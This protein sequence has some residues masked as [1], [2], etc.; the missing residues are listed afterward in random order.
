M[1]FRWHPA[2]QGRAAL[3]L[4]EWAVLAS[5]V[6]VLGGC[7]SALFLVSLDWATRTREA[8]PWLVL[9]LPLGGFAVGLLYHAW[10]KR[11]EGGTNLLLDEIHA[12]SA[13]VPA[14]LAPLV[15]V[16]TVATHLFGGS[17]G[18]EGTAVQM[19][20]SLAATLGRLLRLDPGRVRLL[21]MA[22]ISAGFGS[23]FGT[24]LAGM[25]FGMEVL[26][27][28]RMR[29]YALVP[30]LVASLVGDWTCQWWG[31]PHAHYS[32][33]VVPL[34]TPALVGKVLLASLLFAL[35][36]VAFV[37]LTHL[38][39]ALAKRISYPPFRPFIGGVAV[40]L[41]WGIV[42]TDDYLG[43]SLPLIAA[44]FDP[45]GVAGSAF[46]WKIVFTAVTL[47]AGFKGGEVTPLFGV[48]AALGSALAHPLGMPA[49]FLAALGFAAVFAAAANTPL[50]C[51]VM[52]LELFGAAM[53]PWLALACCASYVLSGH[54][55]IYAS[56]RIG[57]PKGGAPDHDGPL[58][59]VQHAQRKK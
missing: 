39:Q 2:E 37:E 23:V 35:A 46:A 25:V 22:G 55:G 38:C 17:A 5:L 6:G 18:R 40:L 58:S 50:A 9:L 52:G 14:R 51:V 29:Y 10:G 11:A 13:G 31:V 41:L 4:A 59:E 56:Q 34:A 12:P 24:P 15:L 8:R 57:T 30:C 45:E 1:A 49:P 43:L 36:S 19:G 47:G 16:G 27:L 26:A 48:G 42:Q 33:G 53:G 3:H 54:R 7:A 20:G 32:A 21:L 28:G 44:S